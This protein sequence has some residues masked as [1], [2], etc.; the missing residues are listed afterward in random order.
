MSQSNKLIL[1]IVCITICVPLI[2]RVVPHFAPAK[3]GSFMPVDGKLSDCTNRNITVTVRNWPKRTL[4][5]LLSVCPAELTNSVHGTGG[6]VVINS[7]PP[8]TNAFIIKPDHRAWQLSASAYDR[9]AK[10]QAWLDLDLDNVAAFDIGG[11]EGNRQLRAGKKYKLN[12]QFSNAPPVTASLWLR[13]KQGPGRPGS[14]E[15]E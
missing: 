13:W 1:G 15:I 5:L 2:F 8:I 10:R 11:L 9:I 3:E 7:E 14:L 6:F 4:T 12:F